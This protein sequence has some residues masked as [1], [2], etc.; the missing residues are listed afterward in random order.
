MLPNIIPARAPA[1]I[2]DE[3]EGAKAARVEVVAEMGVVE[4]AVGA[5]VVPEDDVDPVGVLL[6]PDDVD[7]VC[8]VLVVPEDVD[9][10]CVDVVP[11][12]ADC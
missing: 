4:D 12:D 9:P 2:A 11:G 10:V 6:V 7:P 3:L 1:V 5:V 8:V